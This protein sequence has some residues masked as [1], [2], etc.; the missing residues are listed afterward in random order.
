MKSHPAM[1]ASAATG[2]EPQSGNTRRSKSLLAVV[3]AAHV[4]AIAAPADASVVTAPEPATLRSTLRLRRRS[5]RDMAGRSAG[6]P[7]VTADVGSVGLVGVS[8]SGTT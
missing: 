3:R 2:P 7:A 8:A 4:P 1:A 6:C 5:D